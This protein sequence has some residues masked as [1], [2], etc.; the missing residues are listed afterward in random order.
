M[1]DAARGGRWRRQR[2]QLRPREPRPGPS[3]RAIGPEADRAG[4][5]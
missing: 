4:N 1:M 2:G 5:G 3:E